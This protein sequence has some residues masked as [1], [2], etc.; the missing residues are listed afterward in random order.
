MYVGESENGLRKRIYKNHF[1]DNA[2]FSTL[3][4]SLGCLMG[5]EQIPRDSNSIQNGKTKFDEFDKKEFTKWIKDK[6]LVFYYTNNDCENV[7]E[8]LI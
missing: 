8:E 7:E 6:L 3:R 2:G 1:G 5:L 4:K